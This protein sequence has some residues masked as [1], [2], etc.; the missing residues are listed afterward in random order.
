[1]AELEEK[2]PDVGKARGTVVIFRLRDRD[3]VGSTFIRALDRYARLLQAA[4]NRLMLEGMNE[5]VVDQLAN[6]D[7]LELIGR[8]GVF[9]GQPE[10]GAALGEALAAAEQWLAGGKENRE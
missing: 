10:F 9:P 6:T 2:L 7:V 5:K 3:E 8:E 1:V 4:G